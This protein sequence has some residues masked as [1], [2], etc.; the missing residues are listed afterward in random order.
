MQVFST[1]QPSSISTLDVTPDG[2]SFLCGGWLSGSARLIDITTGNEIRAF[3]P[4]AEYVQGRLSSNGLYYAAGDGT[5]VS[6]IW[7][8]SSGSLL[9]QY[10][11]Q[12]D[13]V[14]TPAL[15]PDCRC[16]LTG[17]IDHYVR[18]WETGLP[19]CP[20]PTPEPE[21]QRVADM[22][23]TREL[24]GIAVHGEKIFV[25]GG[26]TKGNTYIPTVERYDPSVHTWDSAVADLPEARFGIA[27][28]TADDNIYAMGGANSAGSSPTDSL[29]AYD[30]TSNSWSSDHNLPVAMHGASAVTVNGMIYVGGSYQQP[31]FFYS[32]DP[33][34]WTWH[35]LTNM[36]SGEHFQPIAEIDG[37]L[38][39]VG[40]FGDLRVYDIATDSWDDSGEDVPAE[41]SDGIGAPQGAT[42]GEYFYIVRGD[43]TT[44]SLLMYNPATNSWKILKHL[45][46]YRYKGSMAY[47]NG[48]LY[49]IGG[50]TA[51]TQA[52][53]NDRSKKVERIYVPA[54]LTKTLTLEPSTT[55]VHRGEEVGLT[56]NISDADGIVGYRVALDY[57]WSRLTY[58]TGSASKTGTSTETGWSGITVNDATPS[59]VIFTC[60]SAAD[61]LSAGP[62]TLLKFRILV[63]N[64]LPDYENI[65]ISF[66][67][68]TSINEDDIEVTTQSWETIVY[69]PN[70]PPSFTGGPS[71]VVSEDCGPQV[72]PNWATNIS[73]GPAYEATQSVHF[74]AWMTNA[75]LLCTTPT[76]SATGTLSYE[77]APDMNGSATVGIVLLDDGGTANGG[78][79]SSTSYWFTITV[80]PINDEPTLDPIPDPPA[81]NEDAGE[82]VVNLT[83]IGD[84]D[85]ELSQTLV[86]SASSSNLALIPGVTVTYTSPNSTGNLSY[87][88][89][90]DAN[91]TAVITVKVQDNG[92]GIPPNDNEIIRTFTVNVN[93]V[94]DPPTLDAIP[95]PAPI[96]E[97]ATEQVIS[98]TGI[99]DGDP[100][101]SQS[102]VVSASS[103]NL[104]LIP[105]VSVEYS[106]P[107]SSG[108]LKYAPAANANGTATIFVVVEDNGGNIYPD[109]NATGDVFIVSVS[110]VNDAPSFVM[111]ATIEILNATGA[112]ET[113]PN[114]ATNVSPGPP[115]ESGQGVSFNTSNNQ[116]GS[117]SVQP[118]IDP[119]GTL[120]FTPAADAHGVIEVSATLQDTGGT[121]YGGID[122]SAPQTFNIW[123]FAPYLWGDL[124]ANMKAGAV[125]ASLLLRFDASLIDSFPGYPVAEYPEYYPDPSQPWTSFPWAADVNW[126][127][128]AGT[129]DASYLLQY[130]AFLIPQLPADT[131]GDDW[132]PDDWSPSWGK[133]GKKTIS[134]LFSPPARSA[135][136]SSVAVADS[137][138]RLWA[139]VDRD[140]SSWVVTFSI[141]HAEDLSGVRLAL[142]YDPDY[143][144]VQETQTKWLVPGG[145]LVTN[146]VVPGRFIVAGSL[147]VPLTGG[148]SDLLE[149]RFERVSGSDS[150]LVIVDQEITE[151]NE[152]YFPLANNSITEI[153]LLHPPT[154]VDEWMIWW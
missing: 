56:V 100:E 27:C 11:G 119:S 46:E 59:Q 115:D 64:T 32:L 13:N 3:G 91:G 99:D 30:V 143:V 107:A 83:G 7:D 40:Q 68:L 61:P 65:S 37:E 114:W 152:G 53:G 98:L 31:G 25:A 62:G 36:A 33:T 2:Q 72:V 133:T 97:D 74:Y 80:D 15:S 51:A 92:S 9:E 136:E 87:K 147:T 57:D 24:A 23:T 109:I 121:A 19:L 116:P 140:G 105:S 63:N 39:L 44:M 60:A 29:F 142:Q 129:M 112:P 113:F 103:S 79:N 139:Q 137:P 1:G 89:L 67:A 127:G 20:T 8:V 78:I 14:A 148:P 102:L 52:D 104:A 6:R 42:D 54:L 138:R 135:D 16:I 48:W 18:I 125:D 132:G 70:N 4:H 45:D 126:D 81:I 124:N 38:Y 154:A 5:G 144:R 76:I 66:D 22:P 145:L 141:D 26:I 150:L 153:D 21:W 12:A 47:L 69:G 86:V 117:F 130:Y 88:P 118:A 122:T 49:Y 10:N 82:Q 58:C 146:N 85:P 50:Q 75:S 123:M 93:P 71:Q 111:G 84:G 128:T 151:L 96:L 94:N 134:A 43:G 101:L 95:D 149:I 17:G 73:A 41:Y 120:T 77:P 108:L 110:P 35:P 28:T 106:S 34:T 131:N 55:S 90:P